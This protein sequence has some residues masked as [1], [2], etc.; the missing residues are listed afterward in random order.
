VY[1]PSHSL[2]KHFSALKT[3]KP[4]ICFFFNQPA[5]ASHDAGYAAERF[6]K[7]RRLELLH[8]RAGTFTPCR[9]RAATRER[10]QK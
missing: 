4:G 9:S 5:N 2:I 3:T 1:D 6:P 8:G 7:K 10:L